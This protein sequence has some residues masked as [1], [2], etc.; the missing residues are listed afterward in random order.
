MP[1]AKYAEWQQKMKKAKRHFFTPERIEA[2]LL[3]ALDIAKDSSRGSDQVKMVEFLLEQALGKATTRLE[4]NA[5]EQTTQTLEQRIELA[6]IAGGLLSSLAQQQ[7]VVTVKQLP[8]PE[9]IEGEIINAPVP[10][11]LPEGS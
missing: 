3:E 6:K 7:Q 4:V 1:L 5:D 8:E 2:L 10:D 9:V 11:R